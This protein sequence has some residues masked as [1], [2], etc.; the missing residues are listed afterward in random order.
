[1]AYSN[2]TRVG[3]VPVS[4]V[5]VRVA[6]VGILTLAV[7]SSGCVAVGGT[8]STVPARVAVVGVMALAVESSGGVTAGG[9][10]F[11]AEYIEAIPANTVNTKTKASRSGCFA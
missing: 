2:Q 4:T 8:V 7:E 3:G 10:V 11:R 6:L 5:P 1:V 9:T